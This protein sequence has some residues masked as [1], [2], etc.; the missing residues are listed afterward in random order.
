[1]SVLVASSEDFNMKEKNKAGRSPLSRDQLELRKIRF[2][3]GLGQPEMAER[4]ETKL[5]TYQSYEYARIRSVNPVVMDRARKLHAGAETLGQMAEYRRRAMPKIAG[6]WATRLGVPAGAV[7]ELADMLGVDKSTVSRWYSLGMK[8][9]PRSLIRYEAIVRHQE[10][11]LQKQ[12]IAAGKLTHLGRASG[13]P[14]RSASCE[15]GK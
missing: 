1:V 10:S 13:R 3:L 7:N 15:P 9:G 4:L 14:M 11:R 2:R 8:P 5:T 6:D 12:R